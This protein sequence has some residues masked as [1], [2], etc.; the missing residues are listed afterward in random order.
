M[1]GSTNDKDRICLEHPRTNNPWSCPHGEQTEVT[2]NGLL[3]HIKDK[4]QVK[5][6]TFKCSCGFTSTSSRSVGTHKRYCNGEV[7][8][9][10]KR[11]HKCDKCIFTSDTINRLQVHVSCKH[12][13]IRNEQLKRKKKNFARTEPE[14]QFLA[15]TIIRLKK[16]GMGKMNE[17]A[18]DLLTDR[19]AV[20]IQAICTNT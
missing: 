3:K 10:H 18:S 9:E 4:H 20:A 7:P 5:V 11:K 1:S 8:E 12:P 6:V 17:V 13:E 15:A 14:L 16:E 2:V 19:A